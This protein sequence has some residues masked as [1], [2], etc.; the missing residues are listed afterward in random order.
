MPLKPWG[1]TKPG[2]LERKMWP[3]L[4][5]GD[6]DFIPVDNS[7]HTIEAEVRAILRTEPEA[8]ALVALAYI[9]MNWRAQKI[10]EPPL[11][12]AEEDQKTGDEEWIDDHDLVHLLD[13][14]AADYDMGQLIAT[15]SWHLDAHGEAIWVIDRDRTTTPARLTPFAGNEFTVEAG[16]G[17]IRNLFR[18]TTP[19]GPRKFE[20]EDVV[21]FRAAPGVG[22]VREKSSRLGVAMEWLR[23]SD[24]TRRAVEQ[25]VGIAAWPNLV[26]TPDAAWNP[27]TTQLDEYIERIV[28]RQREKKPIVMLGGGSVEVVSARIRDLVPDEVLDRVEGVVAAVFGVPAVVL[29]YL[30]GIRNSPWSQMKEARRMAYDDAIAPAWKLF[31]RATTR[32][33]LRQVDEDE[34]HF[35]RFDTSKVPALQPDRLEEAAI[36]SQ[37]SRIASVNE[38]R[39]MVGLEP[40][41]DKKAEEIPELTQPDPMTLLGSGSQEQKQ[42]RNL[43]AALRADQADRSVFEWQ[44]TASQEL[45]NDRHEI[46]RLADRHLLAEKA[47]TPSPGARKR[48]ADA[49][50]VYIEGDSRKNWERATEPLI[51]RNAD[52]ALSAIA[53]DLGFSFDLVRAE[54]AKYVKRE[55]GFLVRSISDTTRDAVQAAVTRGIEEGLGAREIAGL[56]ENL[57]A[58]G[59]DRALL[60][61]RTEATRVTNGAPTEALQEHQRETGVR[62]VK[63]WSTA[64]DER[65][66]D[67]HEAME[68]ETVPIDQPFSNGLQ[69]P[70]EP[71]CRCVLIYEEAAA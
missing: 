6:P 56:M 32:Q 42:R 37:L 25:L 18:V 21:Y 53:A 43:F 8:L 29:Q 31:E 60:V 9:A 14:P 16:N 5:F 70:G 69:F 39:A 57:P 65:V 3:N 64:L 63:R 24:A 15:T 2:R 36:A 23:L 48:F 62:F 58:F 1:L 22:P 68:G 49:I 34:T 52:R 59:R 11:M 47:E 10:S 4:G 33:L 41:K 54:I 19:D 46:R 51:R 30:V 12:V 13:E 67:E 50:R 27:T 20:P 28:R 35:I 26:M 71:N 44:I 38:R 7:G 61:A 40:V 17:R 55:V 66:R 45:E